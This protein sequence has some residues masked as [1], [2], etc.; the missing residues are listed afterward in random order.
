MTRE[1]ARLVK[2]SHFCC[3]FK[4]HSISALFYNLKIFL[5]IFSIV[6]EAENLFYVEVFE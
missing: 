3:L 2:S 1:F 6:I 5:K 4:S